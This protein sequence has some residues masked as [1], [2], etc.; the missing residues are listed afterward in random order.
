MKTWMIRSGVAPMVLASVAL[1]ASA[2]PASAQD[3]GAP[4]ARLRKLEAEVKALQRQVFP[5]GDPVLPG[6]QQQQATS[7]TAPAGTPAT[8]PITDLLTRLDAIEAQNTRLTAQVE[9]LGNRVR[10]LEAGR[11]TAE[12]GVPAAGAP[13]AAALRPL[14]WNPRRAQPSASLRRARWWQRPGLLKPGPWK[15]G[16]W[17]RRPRAWRR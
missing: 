17:P 6:A 1:V 14:C 16:L 3:A 4:D 5:G 13:V 9:E 15:P 10:Q 8:T 2:V 7:M 11:G 12:G